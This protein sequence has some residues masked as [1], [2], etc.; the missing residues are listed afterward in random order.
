[1]QGRDL[2]RDK[3]E[4]VSKVVLLKVLRAKLWSVDFIL[5]AIQTPKNQTVLINKG[6]IFIMYQEHIQVEKDAQFIKW[7]YRTV[8][9]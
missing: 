1:M 4:E 7:K 2:G 3:A 6:L 9:E 5:K 8:A